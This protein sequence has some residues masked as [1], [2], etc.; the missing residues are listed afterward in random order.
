IVMGHIATTDAARLAE[1]MQATGIG[2]FLLMGANI[3]ES[4]AALRTLT[5]ALVADPSLPP[6]IAIDQEGGVVRRLGGDTFPAARA[7]RAL[8]ASDAEG[9]FAARSA[10]VARSGAT[11]NFG[12]VA[13]Y[14]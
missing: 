12:I 5:D 7:L 11:V 1:Y 8:P 2:G 13:D 4:E 14:T 6:L 9:A 10:L 3:P